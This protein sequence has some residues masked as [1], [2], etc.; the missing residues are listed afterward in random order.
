[1]IGSENLEEKLAEYESE[2]EVEDELYKTFD[3]DEIR[4]ELYNPVIEAK[5]ANGDTYRISNGLGVSLDANKEP[6]LGT[7]FGLIYIENLD[8]PEEFYWESESYIGA[9]VNNY[10]HVNPDF[11]INLDDPYEIKIIPSNENEGGE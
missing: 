3:E 8:N 4:I 9:A 11:L 2:H 10:K 7:A 6:E 5:S 1:M